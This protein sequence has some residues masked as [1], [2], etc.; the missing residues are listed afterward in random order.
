MKSQDGFHLPA[1]AEGESP[2]DLAFARQNLQKLEMYQQYFPDGAHYLRAC[3]AH[4]LENAE[5]ALVS[6]YGHLG[7]GTH[8]EEIVE[9][10]S[11]LERLA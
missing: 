6:R 8:L 3:I 1:G 2:L 9:V 4:Q 10:R 5:Q 7:A 11:A